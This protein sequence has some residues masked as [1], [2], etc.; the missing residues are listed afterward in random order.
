[1]KRSPATELPDADQSRGQRRRRALL[2]VLL[3]PLTLFLAL[4]IRGLFAADVFTYTHNDFPQ[5]Q[6]T[7]GTGWSRQMLAFATPELNR[8]WAPMPTRAHFAIVP[9]PLT[10]NPQTEQFNFLGLRELHYTALQE[11]SAHH[12]LLIPSWLTALLLALPALLV[13]R[14]SYTGPPRQ[15]FLRVLSALSLLASTLAFLLLA[16]LWIRSHHSLD[17]LHVQLPT[18]CLNYTAVSGELSFQSQPIQVKRPFVYW[19]HDPGDHP[20]ARIHET[21]ARLHPTEKT[22]H[23]FFDFQYASLQELELLGLGRT[24]SLAA[25]FWFFTY[26]LAIPPVLLIRRRLFPRQPPPEKTPT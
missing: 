17:I 15:Y 9:T 21:I 22:E 10:I 7:I 20:S 11:G 6:A 5:W 3:I 16:L 19:I 24:H 18:R 25:P 8:R 4:L 12:E 26:L 2:I 1:M 14:L 23:R 13:W